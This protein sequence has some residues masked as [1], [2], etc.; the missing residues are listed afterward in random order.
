MH[1]PILLSDRAKPSALWGPALLLVLIFL[2]SIFIIGEMAMAS[3]KLSIDQ[4]AFDVANQA[5]SWITSAMLSV[6]KAGSVLWLS[7]LSVLTLLYL[8][9]FSPFSR[10]VGVYFAVNMIGVSSLTKLLKISYSR[11]R[12]EQT[13]YAGESSSFP[14][15]HTSGAVAFY[16][17]LIYLISISHLSSM[18]KWSL[19]I[20]LTLF[21]LAIG[22][23]RIFGSIHFFTDV[24]A[25]FAIGFGWLMICIAGIEIT[26]KKRK[27]QQ[28]SETNVQA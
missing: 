13:Q 16:G 19:N 5:P 8:L 20:V 15:G 27:Q 21:M 11:E 12:P 2:S 25:G 4:W 9:F 10:W 22:I 23:S 7:V 18:T 1:K 26:L 3:G 24:L 6:T 17:F 28:A 14:S